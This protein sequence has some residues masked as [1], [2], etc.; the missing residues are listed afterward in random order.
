VGDTAIVPVSEKAVEVFKQQFPALTDPIPAAMLQV[1]WPD[2]CIQNT[3]GAAFHEIFDLTLIDFVFRKGYQ[4]N[5]DSYSAFFENDRCT[6]TDLYSYLKE[7]GI[8]TLLIGGLATDYCVLYSVIDS[9]RLGFKTFVIL[10]ACMGIDIPDDS[11]K[12][13]LA[14]MEKQGAFFISSEDI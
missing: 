6:P 11:V 8:E 12:K 1:L 13:A 9:L 5:I 3:E 14:A 2:H 4:K 7:Q 10:D